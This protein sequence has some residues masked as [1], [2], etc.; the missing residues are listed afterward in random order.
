MFWEELN[1]NKFVESLDVTGG[2]CVI[3]LGCM[4][5]HGNH[6]PLGTDVYI[7]REVAAR[8]AKQE[9]FMIFPYYP[10]GI[11]AEVKHKA[12]TV[13][14]S[15]QLQFLMLEA[16]CE[17]VSRNGYKKIIFLNGHGGSTTFLNYFVQAT[18]EEP[19]D[20]TVYSYNAFHLSAEQNAELDAKFGPPAPGGHADVQETSQIMAIRPDLVHMELV[21]REE[22]YPLRR[23]E[24]FSKHA[25]FTGMNWYGSY[26]HQF[27]GDPTGANAEYGDALLNCGA[28]NL[29]AIVRKLKTEN[30]IEDLYEEFYS[31]HDHPTL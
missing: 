7:A 2:V 11:V 26:P 1:V 27:A 19:R 24:W 18:L 9:E 22:A 15:S 21:N 5:K 13:A 8:A 12:G 4:E 6:L 20:Y 28:D 25:V 10:L 23:A 17:E 29:A 3:P 30:I 16:I 31:F 14:V